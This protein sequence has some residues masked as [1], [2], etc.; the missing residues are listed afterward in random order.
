M[1]RILRIWLQAEPDLT[2]KELFQRPQQEQQGVY[3]DKMLRTL[4]RRVQVW[5]QEELVGY[6]LA[7]QIL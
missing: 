4:Q 3:P 2:A 5:R 6:S 7:R 1:Q